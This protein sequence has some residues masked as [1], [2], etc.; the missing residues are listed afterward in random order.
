MHVRQTEKPHGDASI[1]APVSAPIRQSH[2]DSR[3]AAGPVQRPVPKTETQNPREF[4][5]NQLRRRYR[6][7]ETP[8]ADGDSFFLQLKPTDPDFPFQLEALQ[9]TIIVPFNFPSQPPSLSLKVG[10]PEIAQGFQINIEKGWNALV[11]KS[12]NKKLLAL[13]NDLDRELES[14]L[15][16]QKPQTIKL[17]PNAGKA[18]RFQQAPSASENLPAAVSD[19][20]SDQA[21]FSLTK[22]VQ[23][24]EE[25]VEN[26]R[27]KRET[28]IRQL[29]ARLGRQPHFSKSGD[30]LSYIVP[31]QFRNGS[32][33]SD[34]MK[35]VKTLRL[36][37]PLN[38]DLEPCTVHFDTIEGDD[39]RTLEHGFEFWSRQHR[40]LS[41]T[42]HLNYFSQNGTALA[43]EQRLRQSKVSEDFTPSPDPKQFSDLIQPNAATL[44]ADMEF[45]DKPHVQVIPRPPEWMLTTAEG[46][47]ASD[48]Y[49]SEEYS[50]SDEDEGGAQIPEDSFHSTPERGILVSFPNLELY[51]IE[52][53]KLTTLS[54]T[55]KCDRCKET[56][57]IKNIRPHRDAGDI[58]GPRQESCSKCASVLGVGKLS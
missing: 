17:V 31:V 48:S 27:R 2:D 4:Q 28:E 29:E 7:K 58:T 15:S 57:D 46:E 9:C 24:S 23:H 13:L 30:G 36:F 11:K 22:P 37:V 47:E 43:E 10:N 54:M 20:L 1:S 56:K 8:L 32:S 41:L 40:D 42:A 33:L 49:D 25:D 39:A 53:L 38:Y 26:A 16:T 3:P 50:D 19:S 44:L 6:P 45:R 14:F 12:P 34:S 51:G 55:I 18:P 35:D 5:I 52:L 21:P